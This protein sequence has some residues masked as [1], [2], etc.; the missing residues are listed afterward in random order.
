MSYSSDLT[1]QRIL[2]CARKAFLKNGY[3]ATK[4]SDIVKAAKVTTGA[5]YRHF[6]NKEELFFALVEEAYTYTLR[7]AAHKETDS[8]DVES[9]MKNDSLESS[10]KQAMS[11]VD[12][13]YA[14]PIEF[15]LLLNCSAGSRMENFV[16]EVTENYFRH[17]MTFFEDAHRAGLI[18]NRPDELAVHMLLHSFVFAVCECIRHGVAYEQANEYIR[19]IVTFHQHGW[20]GLL[21][22]KFG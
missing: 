14:H 4:L 6:R 10:Y 16:E 7:F 20:N 12:Y 9:T 21:G 13:M 15:Q 1:R 8:A 11:I 3:Q 19:S 5:V 22:T 2:D 17:G 18:S